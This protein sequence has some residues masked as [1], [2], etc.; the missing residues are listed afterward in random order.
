[1]AKGKKP[2]PDP[3]W[4]DLL[5]ILRKLEK[6]SVEA[7]RVIEEHSAEVGRVGNSSGAAEASPKRRRRE[8]K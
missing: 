6:L 2:G 7:R 1:M 5:G 3:R 8:R 4:D